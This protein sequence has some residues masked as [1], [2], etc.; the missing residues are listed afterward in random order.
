MS[1]EFTLP[2]CPPD[3]SSLKW[4]EDG[5]L[6]AND[7]LLLVERLAKAEQKVNSSDKKR[8]NL[9]SLNNDSDEAV[10]S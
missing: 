5:E 1:S 8:L 2:M 6:S 9:S 10:A 3:L 7:T 4:G